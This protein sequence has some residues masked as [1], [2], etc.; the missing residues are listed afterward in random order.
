M[1]TASPPRRLFPSPEPAAFA[2]TSP[3]KTWISA[4]P[5]SGTSTPNCVPRSTASPDGVITVKPFAAGGTS[6]ERR[7]RSM[8]RRCADSKRNSAGA[9][10]TTLAPRAVISSTEPAFRAWLWPCS[11]AL[12]DSSSTP[13]SFT[14]VAN[15][16]WVACHHQP[17]P[18]SNKTHAATA[19]IHSAGFGKVRILGEDWSELVVQPAAAAS[20]ADSRL[21]SSANSRRALLSTSS[22]AFSDAISSEEIVPSR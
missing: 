2:I 14:T 16:R 8:W 4:A 17:P 18:A 19:A 9:S 5:R 10:I 12:A 21:S 6:A 13:A 22:S 1:V 3:W 11:F 15:D 20:N 7:P